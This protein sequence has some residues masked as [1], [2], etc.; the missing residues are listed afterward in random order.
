MGELLRRVSD[1]LYIS[2]FTVF[3]SI[4]GGNLVYGQ[5]KLDN[6]RPFEL[7]ISDVSDLSNNNYWRLAPAD[8]EILSLFGISEIG[9][10]S[11]PE[12]HFLLERSEGYYLGA[13]PSGSQEQELMR[14]RLTNST[15]KTIDRIQIRLDLALLAAGD[16]SSEL[17]M[18]YSYHS[19][20]GNE[21]L[22]QSNHF[23]NTED[24]WQS[25]SLNTQIENMLL[26]SG[27]AVEIKITIRSGEG[28]GLADAVALRRFE[29]VPDDFEHNLN[30]SAGDLIITEI[31]PGAVTHGEPLHYVEVYNS[32]H[33][34]TDL[35]GLEFKSGSNVFKIRHSL[36][37]EPFQS[38]IV[39]NRRISHIGFNPDYIISDFRLPSHGGLIELMENGNKIMRAAFDEQR[40]NRSWELKRVFDVMDGYTAMADF[41]ESETF[42]SSDFYGSPGT[43][44]KTERAFSYV[45]D[46][47]HQ[48]TMM[49]AP[50]IFS[51]NMNRENGYWTGADRFHGGVAE[52]QRGSG[53]LKRGSNSQA[54]GQRWI[55]R[56]SDPGNVVRLQLPEEN[57]RWLLLGNPFMAPIQLEQIRPVNGEFRNHPVQVWDEYRQT[58]TVLNPGELIDP[59]QAFIVRNENAEAVLFENELAL[60]SQQ[61][62][63]LESRSRSISFDLYSGDTR[64]GQV[65]DHAARIYFHELADHGHDVFESEKLWPVF[66]AAD[67]AK[68]SL[69]YFIG[70]NN[71]RNSFLAQ[72]SRPY[73]IENPF[74]VKMG[75]IAYNAPGPHTLSWNHFENIPDEWSLQLTDLHTG[76]IVDMRD[77]HELT[78]D[79]KPGMRMLP[80]FSEDPS[81]HP[82]EASDSF[83]RFLISINPASGQINS[84]RETQ[85]RPDRVELYQN[86][87]NPFNPA[88]NIRFYLPEQRS[89]VVGV[90]NVVGQRVA[91]LRDEVLPQ[92]E[93]TVAW[94]ATDMP[95]GIYIIH[96]EIGNQVLTR[97]MTLIK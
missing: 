2:I 52:V 7:E 51:V 22:L 90:Y 71:G 55:I 31:F 67:D 45:P 93:H 17:Y 20:S 61:R 59:W 6:L 21:R 74:E 38:V 91:Q 83:E 33:H 46:G 96:L 47:S 42:F 68:A 39:A 28:E 66:Q 44:G 30:L 82:L 85:S 58:F 62:Q 23:R 69:I 64:Q 5:L 4:T 60:T 29:I 36:E 10:E 80:E 35:R 70:Q 86:F 54:S 77:D 16:R 40:S 57:H 73:N 15:G 27:E 53:L 65:A 24:Q 87:P 78:F 56:E 26:D 49:S 48:W 72:D 18:S 95:S 25:A 11:D 32:T 94:D 92:G 63:R 43:S 41:E 13:R 81:L 75:H 8:S 50:G 12:G 84:E 19:I 79:V 9:N 88:T 14:F 97:K 34:L 1:I 3:V 89:V 37:L 76:N